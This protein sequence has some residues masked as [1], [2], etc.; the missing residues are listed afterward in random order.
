MCEL[1]LNG[2]SLAHVTSDGAGSA[3]PTLGAADLAPSAIAGIGAS[4]AT[5]PVSQS[6]MTVARSGNQDIDGLLSGTKWGSTS[7]TYSFPVSPTSY[8]YAGERDTN[9]RTLSPAQQAAADKVLAQFASYTNLTFTKIGETST[10]HA[11]IRMAQSDATQTAWA[12]YPST[13]PEGGDAWF[14]YSSGYYDDPRLGTYDYTTFLHE[15]GHALGL[16]HGHETDTYGAL[17]SAHNSMEYSVMTYASYVGASTTAGY[18]NE[19]TSYAQSAMMDD[20]AALQRMYGANFTTNATDTVYTWSATNGELSIN[21]VRQGTPAGNH[22]FMTVW[23]G[24]GNDTYDFSNYGTGVTVNLNPG[25]WSTASSAQLARLHWDGSKVAAG[26]IANALLYNNDSRSLIENARG[27]LGADRI[28]GNAAAN[29]L[30]GGAGNDT[31]DGGAGNDLLIGGLGIDSLSGG[32]GDDTIVWDA[33]DNQSVVLGGTGTDTLLA[34]NQPAPTSFSLVLHGFE[35]A[36]AISDDT[37]S[38]QA[39][40]RKTSLFDASWRMV[41]QATV[42]DNGSQE[43]ATFDV[44]GLYSW[45]S[46][47]ETKDIA[48]RITQTR[49]VQDVGTSVSTLL[50]V[51]SN[52]SWHSFADYFDTSSAHVLSMICYDDGTAARVQVDAHATRAWQY[53]T[54][55]IDVA[56][57]HTVSTIQYDDATAHKVYLDYDQSRSWT[58][59][60]DTFD[61]IGHHTLSSIALDNGSA[62]KVYLDYDQSRSWTTYTD[63]FDTSGRHT[64]S[65]IALDN[66]S[67]HKVYLDYDGA[68]SWTTYVDTFDANGVHSDSAIAYDNGTAQK[69]YMDLADAQA[70]DTFTDTFDTSGRHISSTIVSDDGSASYL[71]LDSTSSRSWSHVAVNFDANGNH[72]GSR[73]HYDNGTSAASAIDFFTDAS[74]LAVLL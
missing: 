66:G 17:P 71:A 69:F 70:W 29:T 51:S 52:Q 56:N 21:G 31:L 5:T 15:L 59:Y 46:S 28:T 44:A 10:S 67:A 58:Y 50:D 4:A 38:Q 47:A 9:F 27:G 22:I 55:T 68:R 61:T 42:F 39:W 40:S 64:Q 26:N 19:T 53:Y 1:C 45:T 24:G 37:L 12:Y 32:E 65:S 6:T 72:S 73:I 48:G 30:D 36:E 74:A 63:T 49:E 41:S 13:A 20:I 33:I 3:L 25:G 60:T 35:R 43:R 23:D 11:D 2:F 8:E 54:D 18:S 57:R 7:I 14:N 62:Q 34:L 16:K